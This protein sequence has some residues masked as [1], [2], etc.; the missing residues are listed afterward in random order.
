MNI[1]SIMLLSKSSHNQKW[2]T[3]NSETD[4]EV[5]INHP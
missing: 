4:E 1:Y 2:R 3:K 5:E